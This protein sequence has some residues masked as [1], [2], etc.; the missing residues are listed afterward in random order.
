LAPGVKGEFDN[1]GAPNVVGGREFTLIY[2]IPQ[3]FLLL[4]FPIEFYS[5]KLMKARK[6]ILIVQYIKL[7]KVMMML[8]ICWIEA[9]MN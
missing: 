6:G 8:C 4:H 1:T 9:R 7:M 5:N 3:L 2:P